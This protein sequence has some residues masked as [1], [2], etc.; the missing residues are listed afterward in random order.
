MNNLKPGDILVL[1]DDDGIIV[2]EFRR[3]IGSE[4]T[5]IR[6]NDSLNV[7]VMFPDCK[8]LNGPLLLFRRKG[9]YPREWVR[10]WDSG[11]WMPKALREKRQ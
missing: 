10:S 9:E 11:P 1:L 6:F 2:P 5:F 7:R 4:C 8:F 3:Y